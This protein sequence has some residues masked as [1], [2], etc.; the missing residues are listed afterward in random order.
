MGPLWFGQRIEVRSPRLAASLKIEQDVDGNRSPGPLI[1][2]AS[3]FVAADSV[4]GKVRVGR[5]EIIVDLNCCSHVRD[6]FE[7]RATPYT[8]NAPEH[9]D[10]SRSLIVA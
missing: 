7:T 3:E 9:F 4:R 1:T 5:P 10:I 8:R 2:T 6:R